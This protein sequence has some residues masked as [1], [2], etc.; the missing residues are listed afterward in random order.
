MA[1]DNGSICIITYKKAVDFKNQQNVT[2]EE[3]GIKLGLS[4]VQVDY[5]KEHYKGF[6][7]AKRKEEIELIN[8]IKTE[9]N[10]TA[11]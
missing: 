6:L 5:I 3:A 9:Q 8:Q 10:D 4:P 7:E 11:K 2:F 1:T